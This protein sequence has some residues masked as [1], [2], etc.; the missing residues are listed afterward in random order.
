MFDALMKG[1]NNGGG[2]GDL[3]SNFSSKQKK[4]DLSK[5]FE[6]GAV[7]NNVNNLMVD[8][9][10]IDI[11]KLKD[12]YRFPA[13]I[14]K[15]KQHLHALR[16]GFHEHHDH[17]EKVQIC[18][19]CDQE[20]H[21]QRLSICGEPT[22]IF[23]QSPEKE[24]RMSSSVAFFF[25]FI[26]YVVIMFCLRF[27]IVDSFNL[28]SNIFNG[29]YCR[30]DCSSQFWSYASLIYKYNRED[31]MLITDIL[32]FV[33]IIILLPFFLFYRRLQYNM[34]DIIDNSNQ[35]Q[36]DF[37]IFVEYIPVLDFPAHVQDSGNIQ[38]NYD[39]DL[40]ELFSSHIR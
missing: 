5:V 19:C 1:A 7:L 38:F 30:E 15:A 28:F 2:G 26:K 31:L 34:Y 25:T 21:T 10:M 20:L 37:S 24:F 27:I 22:T 23:S 14:K 4:E 32:S 9:M 40:D 36:D 6:M 11:K 16:Y 17:N 8:V 3:A 18:A 12:K 39:K 13:T 33:C 35:T 29:S